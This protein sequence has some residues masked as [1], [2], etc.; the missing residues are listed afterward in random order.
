MK[1]CPARESDIKKVLGIINSL[2]VNRQQDNWE[3][4]KTGLFE[5]TKTEDEL[6]KSLNPYFLVAEL[7]S[8]IRGYGLSY[9]SKFF[10]D[11]SGDSKGEG[12]RFILNNFKD[13]FVYIDQLGVRNHLSIGAGRVV[14]RI[15]NTTLS[16]AYMHELGQAICYICHEPVKNERSINYFKRKG[17]K[18]VQDVPIENGVV[19]GLYR[20]NF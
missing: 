7:G 17:F 8:D 5:Y 6:R 4:A 9:D 20:L 19:L 16:E 18:F 2:Q 10:R 11:N 13:N 1:I 14:E 3:D 12:Y 15:A